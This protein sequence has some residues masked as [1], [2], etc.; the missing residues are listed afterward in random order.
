MVRA[1]LDNDVTFP[2]DVYLTPSVSESALHRHMID[3][4]AYTYIFIGGNAY[5][6]E[7]TVRM[8]WKVSGGKGETQSYTIHIIA[9]PA[10]S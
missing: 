8:R 2:E 10:W 9:L 5:P 7:H 6:E 1:L 4:S 3:Y